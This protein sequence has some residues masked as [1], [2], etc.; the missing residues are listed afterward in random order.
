MIHAYSELYSVNAQKCLAS[1]LEHA[2]CI[3]G[4]GLRDFYDLF[5]IS[6]VSQ[7]FQH[8]DCSII[9]GRSGAELAQ[10]VLE[11][12]GLE[13]AAADGS[14]IAG[15]SEEYWTGWALAY[16]QWESGRTFSDIDEFVPIEE[17]RAL[18]MPYHEMDIRHFTDH[19][20]M[21]LEERCRQSRLQYYRKRLGLSQRQLAEAA[22]IP[23][24][25]IQQ[26]EQR[27]KNINKAQAAYMLRLAKV[28]NCHVEQLL[29]YKEERT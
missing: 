5:L 18:Y 1:M 9:A 27:Q 20:Q 10:I 26:Y 2:V 16:F 13:V 23:V 17:V 29:E 22:E 6:S 8:G 7:R 12:T 14:A 4:M 28:L 19:M 25:T 11:E 3:L 21:L 24:R 15:R